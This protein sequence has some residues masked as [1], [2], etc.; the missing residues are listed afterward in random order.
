[1]KGNRAPVQWKKH[2]PFLG[3]L[4]L[5][6]S[7]GPYIS[8][9]P[10]FDEVLTLDWLVYPIS[11]IPFRYTIPNNHIFYTLCLSAWRSIL[12]CFSLYGTLYLR[13]LSLIFGGVTVL[14]VARRLNRAGNLFASAS[15]TA[16]FAGCGPLILFST[17]LR[18]YMPA[19]LFSFSAFL[20]AEKWMKFRRK[21]A[22]VLYFL[23]CYFAVWT[24]PTNLLSIGAGLLFLLPL[25]L[26]SGKDFFRLFFLGIV[27]LVAFSAAYVPILRKF[28]KVVTIREGWF[29]YVEF[30]ENYYL[31]MFV[32][33]AP[34]LCFCVSGIIRF[35]TIRKL[36]LRMLCFGG[37][38]LFPL[39]AGLLFQVAP[40]PRVF[41]P[42]IP[43]IALILCYL[44]SG[45]LRLKKGVL[46]KLPLA[47]SVIWLLSLVNTGNELSRDLFGGHYR[48][49]LLCPYPMTVEFQPHTIAK[50]LEKAYFSGD[51]E[52]IFIDFDADPPSL[53]FQLVSRN[54]PQSVVLRDRPD[55]GPV[56]WLA[57]G[58]WIV[59]R[60]K[61]DLERIKKRFRLQNRY[62]LLKESERYYQKVYVPEF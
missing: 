47:I 59:C 11:E 19:M 20:M 22:L 51:F 53:E 54:I 31:T 28:L 14:I 41:F 58:D 35:L 25:G 32:I 56:Q 40:F 39:L 12:S 13:I 18:G 37:V 45:F 50:H 60:D 8:R 55:F 15:V 27:S 3:V 2:I 42:M 10:W 38:L 16:L 49:D 34:L 52:H 36:R 17:A 1:M 30:L 23:F 24:I 7:A 4:L 62:R 5:F 43:L 9:P 57:P 21:R 29:S 48:D 44:L 26:R 61:K 46:Q 33:F 6:F